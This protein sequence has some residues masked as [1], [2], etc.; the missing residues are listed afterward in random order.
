MVL[1]PLTEVGVGMLM[2][3]LIRRRQLVVHFQGDGKRRQHKQYAGQGQR[4]DCPQQP[5][6]KR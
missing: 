2:A 5:A 1:N 3:V 6:A 4:R